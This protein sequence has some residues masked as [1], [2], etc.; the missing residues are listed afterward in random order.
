MR[1]LFTLW[2][3][4]LYSTA[5]SQPV[6]QKIYGYNHSLHTSDLRIT[7]D[8]GYLIAAN[9]FQDDFY[10]IKTDS[11]GTPAWMKVYGGN[12]FDWCTS[13]LPLA[14]GGYVIAG[15]TA[16]FTPDSNT[17]FFL[18]KID[19]TGKTLWQKQYGGE[20]NEWM[21]AVKQTLDGGF[22][23]IGTAALSAGVKGCLVRTD[24]LGNLLWGNNI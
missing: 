6:F 7:L 13:V 1:K 23:I 2:L 16:S 12:Y 4:F 5:F 20:E 15:M 21:G 24:S 14:S 17:D 22:V 3:L 11:L 19:D 18:M 10:L 8:N 9:D